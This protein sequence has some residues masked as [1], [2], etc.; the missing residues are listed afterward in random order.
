VI[1]DNDRKVVWINKAFTS[2]SGYELDEVMGASLG[3]FLQGP[4]TDDNTIKQIKCDLEKGKN[5]SVEILNYHKSGTEYWNNLLIS[6]VKDSLGNI[7]HFVGIQNDISEKKRQAELII[8]H[9]RLDAI[10]Q[11]AA[12]ICHDFNNILGILSG[13]MELLKIQNENADLDKLLDSMDTLILRASTIT[14]RL[15]KSTKKE[16]LPE[17][18]DIDNELLSV[19]EM[20][21]ES[22]S[23]NIQLT[24][25][26][27][28]GK[29]VF[30]IKDALFDSVINLIINAKH[31]ID[32]HGDIEVATHNFDT[33]SSGNDVVISKAKAAC[34]YIVISIRDTGCGIPRENITKIFDPFF[35]TRS[36]KSGTGLGL[37]ILVELV[38]NEGLG[39]TIQS[40]VG[41]G[42]SINLWLPEAKPISTIEQEAVLEPTSIEGLKIVYIDDEESL[43]HVV[44][45]YLESI[46]VIMMCFSNAGEALSYIDINHT[47]IDLVITDNNMPGSVQGQ[48]VYTHVTQNYSGIPCLVITGY[49]GDVSSYAQDEEV[50][51]KPIRFTQ[52]K[53]TIAHIYKHSRQ[54]LPDSIG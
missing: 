21:S 43:L 27:N 54:Y 39:L 15:L 45:A 34:G 35:S 1:C 12:G 40:D 25:S 5:I 18:V 7:T 13:S 26:L 41:L 37:N 14:S 53:N 31:A 33:F 32:H 38:N 44:S 8:R 48:D 19:V 47:S 2:L 17:T 24:S 29:S 51:Q 28:S 9:Q 49:S 23:R 22:I 10:G 50:L 16:L 20:L 6:P 36:H 30:M 4:N 52:L 42:T 11:L 46:G 3:R